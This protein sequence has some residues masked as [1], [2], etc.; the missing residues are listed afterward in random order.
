MN[1][2][3]R[4]LV[5][6]ISLSMAVLIGYQLLFVDPKKD[7][8]IQENVVN[9]LSDSSNIPIPSNDNSLTVTSENNKTEKFKN[10]PRVQL[11]SN[12]TSGSIS[13]KGARI[14][15]ITLTQYRETL[16]ADSS[17][18]NLLLKSNEKNPY[19]I[20]HGW[21]SPDGLKVPNGKT[22]WKSSKNL[23]SPD[24]SITLSWDNGEGI[25]FYQDIS[26]DDT[27]MFTINQR[28]KNNTNNA[29]TLYP[30]GLIRRTGEPE[31]TKFF[32]LH[33][34]PLGVFDG[35]LSEKSYEDL[36]ESG[37]KGINIKPAESGG[38]TGL[39][40]KYW[41]TALLPDQNEK[42]SFTYR[43]LNSSGGQYQTDFLG[44]AVKIQPKSEGNFL[45]RTFAGAKRLA[46][47]DDYEERFN[48]KHFDLAIDFGW[49]YFLT[50]P[51]FYALS[52]ANDYLGNFGLAILAI[53]VLVKIVFF[54]LANKSYKS[55]AKMRNLSPE[56]QKLRERVGDDRQKLNQEM[57]NLYKKEKVNPA[58]GCLPILV[59]IPVFFAL[60]KVLFVSI[61][62][63]QTPFFGWIKDLSV[64]DPTSIL[65]LFGLLPY[66]T[67]I[68]PDFLNLGIWPLLMGVTMFLQQ[69]LNPT[70]PDPIQ[71]KIFAW[72][73][74]AF[75][76]L[77]A[78]FP[79]G[80]VI[81]WTWNNLLSICQQWLIMN[82]MKKK[83]K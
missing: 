58:A 66:S 61:E 81:Y 49:F 70:P 20:E 2:E 22:L 36:A 33:E 6:A 7:Q 12:E 23:L 59:Q 79:A 72:M 39:T 63:R 73:P 44:K 37:Q 80:L 1:P 16:D 9:N 69:R 56:I 32:V 43:Y 26:V 4:N 41:M 13:L 29:V 76:F 8:I 31:T 34:G 82:G 30:Y 19:F 54:P 18:I 77:L 35:T 25:I 57:M 46:L 38:W 27:F 50:K 11:N 75:T 3:T 5:A 65:N 24:T 40:D 10:V 71:A 67:S 15:D 62:M 64:Q 28:V 60:Y 42:Y 83:P 47:F 78:T 14:D 21:S 17:L 52:W 74:V 68:F 51:F 55:M 53:T 45:S 48:V